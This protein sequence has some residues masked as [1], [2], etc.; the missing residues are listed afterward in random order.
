MEA[1]AWLKALLVDLYV[2]SATVRVFRGF[3]GLPSVSGSKVVAKRPEINQGNT[4]QFLGP[5]RPYF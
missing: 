2:F 1:I 3:D 5:Y 4:R